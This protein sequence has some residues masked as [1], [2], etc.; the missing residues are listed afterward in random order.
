MYC[1]SYTLSEDD[2]EFVRQLPDIDLTEYWRRNIVE[3]PY[4]NLDILSIPDGGWHT[5]IWICRPHQIVTT[6]SVRHTDSLLY[7]SLDPA[8]A[9]MVYAGNV[10]YICSAHHYCASYIGKT[11]YD[12]R[13]TVCNTY[14]GRGNDRNHWLS[15]LV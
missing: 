3:N 5:V 10:P 1:Q 11:T 12:S 15:Y 2:L 8:V 6:V 4:C 9:R 13:Y 14:S 7:A